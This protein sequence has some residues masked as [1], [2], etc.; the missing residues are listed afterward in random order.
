MRPAPPNTREPVNAGMIAMPTAGHHGFIDAFRGSVTQRVLHE[1]PGPIL[2]MP[3][4]SG[5]TRSEAG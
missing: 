3:A 1:A 5:S 4:S 2:A